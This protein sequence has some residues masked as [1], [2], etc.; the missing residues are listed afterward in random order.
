MRIPFAAYADDCTVRGEL[1]LE[2]DRLSDLL[3]GADELEVS[4]A[5]FQA[6]EDGRMVTAEAAQVLR[7]DLCAVVAAGPRGRPELR[8]WTRRYPVRVRVGPYAV[9]GYVHAPPTIDPIN[10]ASRRPIVALT[11]SIVEYE[12]GGRLNRE[13]AEAVLVNGLKVAAMD[14]IPVSEV[15]RAT[16]EPDDSGLAASN[17]DSLADA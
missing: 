4:G 15:G 1:E 13:P 2:A 12:V 8:R 17:A 5:S 7:G 14:P 16:A 10:A 6:L 9:T 3:A 11:T